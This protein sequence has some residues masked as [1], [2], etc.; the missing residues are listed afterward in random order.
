[1]SNFLFTSESVA[2]GHPDKVADQISD[3]VLDACLRQ[4]PEAR[5]ACETLV[6][7]GLV[8]LAGEITT[9]AMIDYQAVVREAVKKIGY[10]DPALGFDYRSC[11]VL[12]SI[13][14]QS[15]DISQGVQEGEG[16]FKEMGAGD[17][18]IMFGFA[19][20]ETKEYMPLPITIAHELVR[21]LRKARD[22]GT[23]NYL[24]PDAKTQV[25]VEYDQHHRPIRVDTVVLSTQHSADVDH[26]TLCNDMK[27]LIHRVI[28][29]SLLDDKTRYL[30]N[31]TG[32]FV[33]GGPLGDCGLTGRKVIV[34]T[35]GG[36]GRHGGGAF[37]GKDA[38]KVDRSACYAARYVAK[39]VVAA[40]LADR[41]E[42]QLSYAIGFP[43]PV[44]IKVDTF[45]TAVNT[46]DAELA[47]AIPRA[48]QLDPK[49]IIKMLDLRRPIYQK[50]SW[51]GHFG[52]TDPDFTW[53]K[54]DK[55]EA[56][57]EAAAAVQKETV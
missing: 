4:D 19:C 30:V 42:V 2:E 18:G 54:T 17:Q 44:S 39:N 35:Y 8:M 55:V 12:T 52:R 48:F 38:T 6:S 43:L 27:A 53:E 10:D 45:G 26:A 46:T 16:V 49:G 37:S 21:E 1:M 51:G 24:K 9:H 36:M 56:M 41:C 31:P 11:S 14:K 13:N 40:G 28:P 50:T 3:A 32:R 57:K 7:S 34:D 5:V 22:A 25:T 47:K 23:P 33:T 15:P 29:E 20:N